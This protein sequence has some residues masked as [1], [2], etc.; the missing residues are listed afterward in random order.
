MSFGIVGDE[1]D[2]VDAFD[3][4][5]RGEQVAKPPAAAGFFVA[6]AVDG[7]AEERDFAAAFGGELARL[8]D[9]R[10]RGA[11]LLGAADAGD[12]AV[13]AELVAADHDADVRLVRRGS[14]RGVAERVEAFVAAFDLVAVAVFAA[15][16][17]F[18]PLRA[19]RAFG[20]NFAN[21]RGHL[22]QLAGADDR[23]RRTGRV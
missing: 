8:G 7:L 18:H 23:D 3:V 9:D 17:D 4:V 19:R 10:R 6:V 13:R 20:A 16:A 12:D 21:E 5:Q 15:E 11:A 2:A 22:V 14:H 1:L